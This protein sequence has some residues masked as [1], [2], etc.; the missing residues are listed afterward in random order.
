[1]SAPLVE[2]SREGAVCVLLLRRAEK[3]N[4]LSSALERE[5]PRD[6]TGRGGSAPAQ[7]SAAHD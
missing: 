7:V 3:L 5:L 1:M 2:T 6:Y 4:A